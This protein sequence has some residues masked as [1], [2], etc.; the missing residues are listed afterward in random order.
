M[1]TRRILSS[2]SLISDPVKNPEGDKIADVKDVMIDLS[3]GRIAYLVV[4]Y[5]GFMHVGDKYFAVPF[6]AVRVDQDDHA[7]VIDLDEDVLSTAPGFDKDVWPDFSSLD[8]G[9]DVDAHYNVASD[10]LLT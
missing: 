2:S 6:A 1:T 9:R 10:W 5:G 7:V 4:A 8:W 3:T